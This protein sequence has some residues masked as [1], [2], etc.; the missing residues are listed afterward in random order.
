MN[1]DCDTFGS[2]TVEEIRRVNTKIFKVVNPQEIMIFW[3][4]LRIDIVALHSRF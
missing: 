3:L 4:T 2:S 1:K